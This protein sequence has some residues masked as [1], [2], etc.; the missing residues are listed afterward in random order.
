MNTLDALRAIQN[1]QKLPQETVVKLHDDGLVEIA[2]ATNFQSG[3]REHIPILITAKGMRLLEAGEQYSAATTSLQTPMATE[4]HEVIEI[5]NQLVQEADALLQIGDDNVLNMKIDRWSNRAHTLLSDRGL[6]DEANA[7][8]GTSYRTMA[9]DFRGNLN[10]K[11][12]SRE[13]FLV[14]LRDDLREHPG[15]YKEKLSRA[16]GR[17]ATE[18]R[19]LIPDKLKG[20]GPRILISHSSSDKD[21]AESIIDLLRAAMPLSADDITCSSVEGYRLPLGVKTDDELNSQVIGA[22]L[23]IGLLTCHSLSSAYVLFE[24]GARWGANRPMIP[25]WA[26]IDHSKIEGPIKNVNAASCDNEQ[27]LMQLVAEV[28]EL[29]GL[30]TEQPA[31][32]FSQIRAVVQQ[33][34]LVSTTTDGHA[35]SDVPTKADRAVTPEENRRRALVQQKLTGQS[36]D[37]YKILRHLI[38]FGETHCMSLEENGFFEATVNTAAAV[39]RDFL[40]FSDN[41]NS[42]SVKPEFKSAIDF[43]LT[44]ENL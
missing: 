8:S 12:Q 20:D 1:H 36:Q 21:L 32:Y 25:L 24:L 34:D 18:K 22:E 6:P 29:L 37:V 11:I 19:P 39:S 28:A 42:M 4:V 33:C 27:Q 41:G 7:L 43:F 2:D 35:P 17:R 9:D 38:D 40:V 10:R 5:L 31:A 3:G 30:Q 23:L 14:G 15:F 26:G 13:A 44:S 16:T